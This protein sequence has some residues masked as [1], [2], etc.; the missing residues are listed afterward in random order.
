MYIR[1]SAITE[2]WIKY[3]RILQIAY[4]ETRRNKDGG[5]D[6]ENKT[7]QRWAL[8]IL[9]FVLIA[10]IKYI[11][12]TNCTKYFKVNLLSETVT[13]TRTIF[14]YIQILEAKR[15]GVEFQ[16]WDSLAV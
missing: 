16:F 9:N 13:E 4:P 2:T 7:K 15:H 12:V 6:I 14:L 3:A 11:C 8:F 5:Q 10:Y 1:L